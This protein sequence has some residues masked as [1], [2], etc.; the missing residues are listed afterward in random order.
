MMSCFLRILSTSGVVLLTACSQV[1]LQRTTGLDEQLKETSALACINDRLWTI[2]DSGNSAEIFQIDNQGQITKRIDLKVPNRDWEALSAVGSTL[3]I[4]DIGDNAGSRHE[5][6]LYRAVLND[7]ELSALSAF[8]LHYPDKPA[9]PLVAYAHDFDAEALVALSESQLLLFSKSWASGI[10]HVYQID[11]TSSTNA[12]MHKIADVTGLPGVI[13]DAT[14]VAGTNDITV[15]GYINFRTQLLQFMFDR[16]MHPFIATLDAKFNVKHVS[17]LPTT[18]QV[19]AVSQC[20]G[21]LWISNEQSDAAAAQL[22]R[23]P[24]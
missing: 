13:T 19:E 10:S 17:A 20:Q 4:A 24:H 9:S 12:T 8:S 3:F 1:P 6:V 16:S 23:L 11:I 14:R 7:D 5:L 21:A 2:N 15:V 18:G 22:Q